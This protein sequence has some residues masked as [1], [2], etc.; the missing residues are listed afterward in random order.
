MLKVKNI[1]GGYTKK[2]DIVHDISFN[3]DAGDVV[4]VLGP[5]GCGKTTLFK[6]LLGFLPKSSGKVLLENK[7][8][9]R[10]NQR[11][12]A[13]QIAYIPQAHMPA[14]NYTVMEMILLGRSAHILP[15][16]SPSRED[17][18]MAKKAMEMLSIEHLS[19]KDYTKISGGE[20]QLV[21]IA[22]AICQ[23]AQVLIMDEPSANLDYA[24]QQLVMKTIS[25]LS[26]EGFSVLISTHSPEHPFRLA[27][28]ALL[29]KEG[30]C[31]G[32]GKT[33]EVLSSKALKEAYGINIE[34]VQVEDSNNKVHSFCLSI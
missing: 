12:I 9:D 2:N 30:R 4:C 27:N 10:L 25:K 23:Q 7:E 5:N 6:M 34:V 28:K 20:R 32:F 18:Q 13:K 22:R 29:M 19:K 24:N 1:S 11:E 3:M 33:D 16:A 17:Y 21:L 15:L 26:E 8:L 31:V 14:F